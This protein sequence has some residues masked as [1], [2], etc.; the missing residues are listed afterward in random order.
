MTEEKELIDE[1]FYVVKKR[2]GTWDSYDKN[3]KCLITSLTRENCVNATR[4][5]LKGQQEGWS[6][7][8]KTHCG[9]V[10]GKL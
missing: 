8:V 1:C 10:A 5:Y 4:F 7:D 2:F 9:E 3:G 6:E